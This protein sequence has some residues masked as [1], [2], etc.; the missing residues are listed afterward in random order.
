MSTVNENVNN[1][2][3]IFP[4]DVNTV[5]YLT[6]RYGTQSQEAHYGL[7]LT[8]VLDKDASEA[9]SEANS[10]ATSEESLEREAADEDSRRY[11]RKR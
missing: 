1:T 8:E 6:P 2:Q 4:R 3:G 11:R 9:N 10:E 7:P 5:E